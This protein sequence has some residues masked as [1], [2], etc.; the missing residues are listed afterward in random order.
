VAHE[1]LKLKCLSASWWADDG[2]VVSE[3]LS[4]RFE[5]LA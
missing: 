4:K 5:A 2:K 1:L 3:P